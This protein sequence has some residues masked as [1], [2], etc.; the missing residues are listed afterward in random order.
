LRN[1]LTLDLTVNPDF[2]QVDTDPGA[3]ALDGFQIFFEARR[4][5]FIENKNIFD[6][7]FADGNDNIFK[8]EEYVGASQGFPTV[9][10]NEF[11][12]QPTNSTILGAAK[13]S[14]KT[15]MDGL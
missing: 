11:V 10:P 15:K 4:P 6:Y 5:F 8:V 1:D 14:G 7:E 12:D 9:T 2:G 13:F 3:I